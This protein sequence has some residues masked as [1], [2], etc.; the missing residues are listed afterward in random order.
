MSLCFGYHVL[1]EE[2][3]NKKKKV[4]IVGWTVIGLLAAVA[5]ELIMPGR[6]P[7]GIP[8]TLL[9]GAT[10]ALLG[11]F[12]AGVVAGAGATE[13]GTPSIQLAT[14]GALALLALYRLIANLRRTSWGNRGVTTTSHVSPEDEGV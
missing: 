2:E 1:V 8:V 10:G 6:N 13:F 7:G 11:L 14:L 4:N 12:V 9:V 3:D 5:G